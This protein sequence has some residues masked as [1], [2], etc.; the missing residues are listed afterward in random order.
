MYVAG[1]SAGFFGIYLY[2]LSVVVGFVDKGQVQ[3]VVTSASAV[4]RE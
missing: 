4:Q 1:F 3:K 2:L